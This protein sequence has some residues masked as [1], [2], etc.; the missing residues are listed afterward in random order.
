MPPQKSLLAVCS[1]CLLLFG[2]T[3]DE[4]NT[5][6][7]GLMKTSS[8]ATNMAG[9]AGN[10][11]VD[12]IVTAGAPSSIGLLTQLARVRGGVVE[13][14]QPQGGSF[15]D[16]ELVEPL[17][18]VT[19]FDF[20]LSYT[21]L[22]VDLDAVDGEGHDKYPSLSGD[23]LVSASAQGVISG[24]G[25]TGSVTYDVTIVFPDGAT[26]GL[27]GWANVTGAWGD[28][29]T[30]AYTLDL[31]WSYTSDD[32]WELTADLTADE[33]ARS[34]TLTNTLTTE[35]MSGTVTVAYTV[36]A[37][38]GKDEGVA[39][40]S[41]ALDGTRRAQWSSAAGN[42]NVL[43]EVSQAWPL[44]NPLPDPASIHLTIDGTRYGPY[45]WW[46]VATLANLSLTPSDSD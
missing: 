6:D 23:A 9:D 40:V 18:A 12:A 33:Q 14:D 43:W 3:D 25:T 24:D 20:A 19:L 1:A 38:L 8:V 2:C 7:S 34:V 45:T 46:Q 26:A 15:L 39:Y 42:H 44:G 31:S 41:A 28:G 35:E 11:A 17:F 32:T 21:D 36:A 10:A 22:P 30:L 37:V 13:D 5:P 29:T 27:D 16:A 4:T